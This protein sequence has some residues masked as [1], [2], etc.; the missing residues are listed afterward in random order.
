MSTLTTTSAASTARTFVSDPND[1][2]EGWFGSFLE[3]EDLATEWQNISEAWQVASVDFPDPSQTAG[4]II[5][6]AQRK[7]SQRL[8]RLKSTDLPDV[9]PLVLDTFFTTSGKCASKGVTLKAKLG[10]DL[11]TRLPTC[12]EWPENLELRKNLGPEPDK[13]PFRALR[14]FFKDSYEQSTTAGSLPSALLRRMRQSFG[15]IK[16]TRAAQLFSEMLCSY[17][18]EMSN[19]LYSPYGRIISIV[20]SSGFGKSALAAELSGYSYCK[21][22]TANDTF[23]VMSLTICIRSEEVGFP[24]R[25]DGIA[26]F[27]QGGR[28]G[29]FTGQ[30]QRLF[31]TI[32][33]TVLA[34]VQSS[35]WDQAA[36]KMKQLAVDSQERTAWLSHI[37]RATKRHE[38]SI[39]FERLRE[40][41]DTLSSV[42]GDNT[43][44]FIGLDEAMN[45]SRDRLAMLRRLFGPQADGTR[46][47]AR[48][49]LVLLGTSSQIASITPATGQAG[50]DRVDSGRFTQ[51]PPFTALDILRGPAVA[52]LQRTGEVQQMACYSRPLWSTLL[53]GDGG[54]QPALDAQRLVLLKVLGLNHEHLLQQ[55]RERNQMVEDDAMSLLSWRVA[56]HTADNAVEGVSALQKRARRHIMR[57]GP[58][59]AYLISAGSTVSFVHPPEP[60]VAHYC[61]GALDG[62]WVAAV[63]ALG[64]AY[65]AEA[66]IAG[67]GALGEVAAQL[68]LMAARDEAGRVRGRTCESNPPIQLRELLRLLLPSETDPGRPGAQALL[69]G[70]LSFLQILELKRPAATTLSSRFLSAAYAASCGLMGKPNQP[71]W[72]I[73]LPVRLAS[74]QMSYVAVQV[75][76]QTDGR[77]LDKDHRRAL[78]SQLPRVEGDAMR[79]FLFLQLSG[80]SAKS[81]QTEVEVEDDVL[82]VWLWGCFE[83]QDLALWQCIPGLKQAFC[84]LLDMVAPDSR[85]PG[86]K[87]ALQDATEPW[88]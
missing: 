85:V 82:M 76:N 53:E 30:V 78:V 41:S 20:Q 8:F 1:E 54:L 74:D 36:Q 83:S 35:G 81:C 19:P 23:R 15:N 18:S 88:F 43:H 38:Q 17:E 11:W 32:F 33:A 79:C 65:Y 87:Q 34:L 60:L 3:Q 44:F 13:F 7:I 26:D 2:A 10:L 12:L 24:Y 71:V 75:K 73:L 58:G 52:S 27:L 39:P 67:A 86:L 40:V 72:D 9:P 68:L 16:P 25:D 66:E 62:I 37:L 80:R 42:L 14:V 31:F 48:C 47:A 63:T 77:R 5:Y 64:D 6:L 69:D 49:W 70:T 61:A 21:S 84:T 28:D 22:S 29:D 4:Y 57:K 50:S 59:L 51:F 55:A 45:L 46:L 56:F